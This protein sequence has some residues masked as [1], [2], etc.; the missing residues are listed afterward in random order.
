M[1][2]GGSQGGMR[3]VLFWDN[4]SVSARGSNLCIRMGSSSEKEGIVCWIAVL[5]VF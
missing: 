4:V 3:A 5:Y 2:G 1:A